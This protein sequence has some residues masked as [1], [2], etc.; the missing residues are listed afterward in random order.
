MITWEETKRRVNLRKHKID[1][2]QLEP[3]F[4]FPMV[5][6]EDTR[7]AYGEIR[8]QSLAMWRGQVVFLVWSPRGDET[9]HLISC[10]HADRQET[11]AYFA[12]L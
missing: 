6:V 12:H 9:A 8:L 2:A 3:L 7:E 5:T 1:L 4:D 10:R 11:N